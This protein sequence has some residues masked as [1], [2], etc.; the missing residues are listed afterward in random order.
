MIIRL[1]DEILDCLDEQMYTLDDIVSVSLNVPE[2]DE[3]DEIIRYHTENI[4]VN[5]FL[6]SSKD[7]KYD[8]GYGTT[9]IDISL[10]ILMNDG[11]FFQRQE[12]DGS[13]WF[14]YYPFRDPDEPKANYTIEEIRHLIQEDLGC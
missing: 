8:D 12:Y 2:Y 7:I 5:K 3:N 6:E 9:Y 14:E 10:R 1:Y 11:G 13:E 4:D